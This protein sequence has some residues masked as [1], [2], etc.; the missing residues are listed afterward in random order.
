MTDRKGDL[1][2]Q[3]NY[4]K[5]AE[6]FVWEIYVYTGRGQ[7]QHMTALQPGQ[8]NG[9]PVRFIRSPFPTRDQALKW[10][11]ENPRLVDTFLYE[12]D[13]NEPSMLGA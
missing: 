1:R 5:E 10:I 13:P 4:M 8:V 9:L 3:Q 6:R 12:N 7:W 11:I 2:I